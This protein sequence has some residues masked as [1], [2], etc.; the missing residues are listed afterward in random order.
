M[1]DK[2]KT[3]YRAILEQDESI[4]HEL[5]SAYYREGEDENT[6]QEQVDAFIRLLFDQV[7]TGVIQGRFAVEGSAYIGFSLWAVDAEGFAFSEM[8]GYGT[9]LEIGFAPSCRS[10]GHGRAFVAYI[11]SWFRE[12][13]VGRCY[14][15][16]Y[17]PARTFWERCGYLDSGKTAGSGLPILVKSLS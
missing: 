17:G 9:I 14:V 13:G 4:F 1:E 11:E 3:A 2:R 12:N 8:P 16:A 7:R 5:L 10:S 15:C 6:P